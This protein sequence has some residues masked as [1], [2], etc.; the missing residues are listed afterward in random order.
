MHCALCAVLAVLR[1]QENLAAVKATVEGP[2]AAADVLVEESCAPGRRRSLRAQPKRT[3][4]GAPLP[5]EG[6]GGAG[7]TAMTPAGSTGAHLPWRLRGAY[8]AGA[9]DKQ[10]IIAER[11]G[12][13]ALWWLHLQPG[14]QGQ[15][16]KQQTSFNDCCT[17]AGVG[18]AQGARG[19]GQ[20]SAPSAAALALMALRSDMSRSCAADAADPAMAG[21]CCLQ[22]SKGAQILVGGK[23][24]V[25]AIGGKRRL[26]GRCGAFP[27]LLLLRALRAEAQFA[28]QGKKGRRAQGGALASRQ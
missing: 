9:P 11:R 2:P 22:R 21:R 20:Q 24:R 19:S 18:A 25:T 13:A 28:A 16:R 27:H 15:G 6:S 8:E 4:S 7:S 10:I 1:R 3:P 12:G 14:S 5:V 17:Q 23:Q 26:P